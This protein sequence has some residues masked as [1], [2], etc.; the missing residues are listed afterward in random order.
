MTRSRKR[1]QRRNRVHFDEWKRSRC[2]S[3][4]EE[5]GRRRCGAWLARINLEL[6]V[7]RRKRMRRS[8]VRRAAC[9]VRFD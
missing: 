4:I 5:R 1:G 3:L 8:D 2:A 7:V 9:G 6:G